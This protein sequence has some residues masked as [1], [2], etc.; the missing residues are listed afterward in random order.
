M[1]H[2]ERT[3]VAIAQDIEQV[4]AMIKSEA[5][6]NYFVSKNSDLAR[7]QNLIRQYVPRMAM[8]RS[9]LLL[10]TALNY[11]TEDAREVL[12]GSESQVINDFYEKNRRWKKDLTDEFNYSVSEGKVGLSSDPRIAYSAGAGGAVFALSLLVSKTALGLEFPALLPLVLM[13]SLGA[14]AFT[15]KQTTPLAINQLEEDVTR[16]LQQSLSKTKQGLQRIIEMYEGEFATFR[17]G[18][19]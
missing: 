16:Y 2:F 9:S 13:S 17:Q 10:D 11:L 6:S 8:D 3:K 19:R 18:Y 12:T 14:S 5:H 1:S 15:Y 4:F 7:T